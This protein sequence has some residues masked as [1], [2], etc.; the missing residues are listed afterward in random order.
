MVRRLGGINLA[1]AAWLLLTTTIFALFLHPL[2]LGMT[3]LLEG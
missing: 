2:Q 3:R 1:G